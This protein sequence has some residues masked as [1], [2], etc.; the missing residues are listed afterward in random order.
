[1]IVKRG[2]RGRTSGSATKQ[3]RMTLDAQAPATAPKNVKRTAA[4]FEL[5][6]S[7]TATA[8]NLH[9]TCTAVFEL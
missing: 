8:L 4:I 7:H 5:A 6:E 3:S 2:R 9:L 1:M